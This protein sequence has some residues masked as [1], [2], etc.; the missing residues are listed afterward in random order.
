ME[1]WRVKMSE[2]FFPVNDLLRRK[3]QTSLTIITL[4]LSIASTLFLLLFSERIGF[5]IV[6]VAEQTLTYGL[7]VIFSQFLLFVGIL[8]F[9]VGAII[10]SFIV[11][12]MMKQRTRD[13]G[14]IK[15][16]GCPNSLVFGYFMTELLLVTFAGCVLGV[17]LGFVADF[18]VTNVFRFQAYQK[19]LD[20]W[21]V[22]LVFGVFFALALI[23]GA[24]PILDAARLSPIKALSPVQYF[25]LSKGSKLKPLSRFGIT[26]RL[27]S[28]SLFRR[29]AASV[30][31]IVL[32]SIV[33]VLLTVSICGGIVANSTTSS[34]VEE[35][36]G[37]NII[38]IAHD[39][40]G[41]QY[42]LLLSKFFG[43]AENGDFDYLDEKLAI[44][45]S[46]LQQLN[47][48]PEISN[49]DAR[50][51]LKE[52]IQEMR[53]YKIDPETLVTI[54][55]GDN[56][57]GDSLVVGVDPEQMLTK[58]F[59]KGQFLNSSD[60]WEAVVGDTLA[61][62]MYSPDPSAD[63]PI[64]VSDPLLQNVI[65][66]GKIFK[67]TGVHIDP[68]NSGNV[69]YIPLKNLQNITNISHV[70]IVF[71]KLESSVDRA[72][73]LAQLREKIQSI[74]SEFTVFELDEV[75]QENVAFIGSIWS[76]ILL[77]PLFTLTS[78]ALCL[79]GYMMLAVDEQ[80]Q[81]FAVLRAT[82]TNPK[83]IVAILAVQSVIVLLSSCAVGISL[84][85]ITTL[86]ILMP[87]PVVTSVTILEIAAWLFAA[88][89]GMF[90]LSLY[91]A[92]KFAKTPL[93]KIMA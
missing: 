33:F 85:V 37:K 22:P 47:A 42:K 67:I 5:G 79:I 59:T 24:K 63:P 72:A 10:T 14:L 20:L 73:A 87:H 25:G 6:S 29:Q 23:F 45:D 50:L 2:T 8:I 58:G 16:A 27:A 9:A 43:A 77:L 82:G 31:I 68:I 26:L 81:E 84:G 12:L 44:P 30:R 17:V 1:D 51:I 39:S 41:T 80:R 19:S 86:M 4:T 18:A 57:S 54:P 69:T 75:L 92:V 35:A 13:F 3:L 53:G 15:A 76:T 56:R 52:R 49:I 55:V 34:W 40:M 61:Q 89:S 88:L 66:R 21:L 46:I 28:R 36:V 62:A 7:S 78:A 90:L 32:L 38:A 11:F 65:V 93:L 71:V 64:S 60:A 74:N 48:T 83:A 91:P 70:N